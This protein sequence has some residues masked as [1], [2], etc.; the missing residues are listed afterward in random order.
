M[1][2][3]KKLLFSDY[4]IEDRHRFLKELSHEE[5]LELVASFNT[6]EILSNVNR[7]KFQED[8]ISD[9]LEYLYRI[10]KK[11]FWL[12]ITAMFSSGGDGILWSDNFF[13]IEKIRS[14]ELPDL[15]FE[16]I[17]SYFQANMQS[18]D[19]DILKDI[20]A[21]QVGSEFKKRILLDFCGVTTQSIADVI[22]KII[23]DVESDSYEYIY[24]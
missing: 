12:H 17:L 21:S 22:A 4:W 6:D 23:E 10:S 8:Y 9:Y 24:P 18:Q 7:R 14:E 1:S 16:L 5:R 19:S 3:N 20:I 15:T 13:Y 2:L 11:S